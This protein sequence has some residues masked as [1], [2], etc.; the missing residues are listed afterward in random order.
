MTVGIPFVV[1]GGKCRG[2]VLA[3]ALQKCTDSH[4]VVIILVLENVMV[5]R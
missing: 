2:K 1:V 3:Y 5:S 4:P